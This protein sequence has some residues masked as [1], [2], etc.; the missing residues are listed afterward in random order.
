MSDH[1]KSELSG[2]PIFGVDQFHWSRWC[3]CVHWQCINWLSI[4]HILVEARIYV[5][6]LWKA[7][8]NNVI[9]KRVKIIL[10]GLVCVYFSMKLNWRKL[11]LPHGVGNW[12]YGVF[13]KMAFGYHVMSSAIQEQQYYWLTS[14]YCVKFCH[15]DIWSQM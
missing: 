13:C 4:S 10:V 5:R 15:C 8:W 3:E 9:H 7:F 1:M 14:N 2:N 6:L 11:H 12:I